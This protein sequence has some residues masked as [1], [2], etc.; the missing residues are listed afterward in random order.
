VETICFTFVSSVLHIFT[1][2]SYDSRVR[3]GPNKR[4][5]AKLVFLLFLLLDDNSNPT[6]YSDFLLLLLIYYDYTTASA[7][8]RSCRFCLGDRL[9][10]RWCC[11]EDNATTH[12]VAS[13]CARCDLQPPGHDELLRHLLLVLRTKLTRPRAAWGVYGTAGLAQPWALLL[14][15]RIFAADASPEISCLAA[16]LL[17]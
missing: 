1:S 16:R 17:Q 14:L 8:N 7:S 11:I 3:M 5:V 4:W 2:K 12:R 9:R 6:C 13:G 15:V 10:A